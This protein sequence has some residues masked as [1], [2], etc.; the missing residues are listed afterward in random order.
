M[1]AARSQQVVDDLNALFGVHE[2]YRTVHAKGCFLH[3]QF[4]AAPVAARLTRAPHFQGGTVPVTARFS[5]GNGN[6][7]MPD[8]LPDVRGLAVSFHLPAGQRT[9]IVAAILPRFPVHTP[10][11]VL[12]L[13]R[14]V[15]PRLTLPL[16]TA[17]FLLRHPE[18]VASLP[19]NLMALRRPPASYATARYYA[20]HAFKWISPYG[21]ERFVRYRWVPEQESRV[22]WW[23]AWRLGRDYLQD[24]LRARLDNGPIRM[25][26]QVQVARPGDPLDDPAA[27]WPEDREIVTVG[28]LELQSLD[29]REEAYVFDPLRIVDGIGLSN[30]PVL[31]FRT[32]VY[33]VSAERRGVF[34]RPQHVKAA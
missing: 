26:L 33:T 25:H 5:N 1:A 14:A 3:G 27:S 23:R 19:A 11:G 10:E 28:T 24:E 2:G 31:L 18:F 4:T 7:S 15:R 16:H 21:S 8:Y 34:H 17:W 6:P 9:D 12:A 13:V 32:Q 22:S 20:I 29:E 30:D